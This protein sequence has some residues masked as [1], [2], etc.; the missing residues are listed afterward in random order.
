M[1]SERRSRLHLSAI[2]SAWPLILFWLGSAGIFSQRHPEFGFEIFLAGCLLLS[3]R[4]VLGAPAARVFCAGFALGV[5]IEWGSYFWIESRQLHGI[6]PLNPQA[7]DRVFPL[8]FQYQKIW[9]PLEVVLA[10][11]EEFSSREV[12][13]NGLAALGAG[14]ITS[15]LVA[16][17]LS[18]VAWYRL[19]M[20]RLFQTL[21]RPL[22]RRL[23]RFKQSELCRFVAR[24]AFSAVYGLGAGSIALCGWWAVFGLL[25]AII[26]AT[27][28]C[29][30]VAAIPWLS[31]PRSPQ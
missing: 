28:V 8:T 31:L 24:I 17:L 3:S 9:P 7:F 4:L 20:R 13:N 14:S 27:L 18:L 11:H 16:G 2:A 21:N 12:L 5:A 25:P 23:D 19:G 22:K 1:D 15:G 6:G 30:I 29:A 26:C 10:R